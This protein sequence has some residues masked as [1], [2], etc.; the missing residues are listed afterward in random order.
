MMR[1]LI[2]LCL[3]LL[4]GCVSQSQTSGLSGDHFDQDAAAKTRISL[5]LTYLQNGNY[6]QAKVNLDKA[7]Q[8]AP[9]M[10][11]AHYSL[12]YYYQLVGEAERAVASYQ[13]AMKL[14]PQNA[15]I[16][17]SYG[18]F[19]CQQGDYQQA[20]LYFL[21]A[22]N[23]QA[24]AST[25]ETYENLALCSQSQGQM[26]E[27]IEYLQNAIK[28]SPSRAKSLYLLAQW[29][30]GQQ[31][32]QAA[33]KTLRRYQRVA[34][35]S[36]ESLWLTAEIE[37]GLGNEVA[38]RG[39][40][41]MLISRYPDH[42]NTQRYLERHRKAVANTP[43]TVTSQVKE[44]IDNKREI[45]GLQGAAKQTKLD[46]ASQPVYHVV[47]KGENLYRISLKYNIRM[48]SLMDW[49][50]L[51]DAS[52]LALGKKLRIVDPKTEE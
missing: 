13:Q 28:H 15:D 4:A 12:A 41:D 21:Q 6:S 1:S 5:G 8:F 35:V 37:H 14:A 2:A 19:L 26:E 43:S 16:S 45:K 30:A 39:Y 22:I 50:D 51:D 31:Q 10:A 34:P 23:N 24:Y 38:S 32:W 40:G 47:Q 25:A 11:D 33:R 52:A 20:K 18:A 29:Q 7:L 27:A 3:L 49:N 17:N 46:P 48:Q 9:H 44:S 36:A 42:P